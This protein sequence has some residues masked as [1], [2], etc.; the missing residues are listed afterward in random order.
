MNSSPN[1]YTLSILFQI[2]ARTAN[3]KALEIGKKVFDQ[4]SW[5]YEYATPGNKQA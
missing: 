4:M 3:S 5:K 2:C 1:E